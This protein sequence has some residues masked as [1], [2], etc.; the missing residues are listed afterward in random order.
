VE[1][2]TELSGMNYENRVHNSGGISLP[3]EDF[4]IIQERSCTMELVRLMIVCYLIGM[5]VE[6]RC[7]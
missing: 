3:S 2:W 1:G 4:Q 5:G 6:F 7:K